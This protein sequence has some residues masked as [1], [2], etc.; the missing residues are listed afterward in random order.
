[1]AVEPL[2]GSSMSLTGSAMSLN[3][4][5]F[6]IDIIDCASTY[7]IA[8]ATTSPVKLYAYDQNCKASLVQ[9]TYA[10]SVY[11][12]SVLGDF[13]SGS[14]V[15]DNSTT[16]ASPSLSVSVA[17]QLPSPLTDASY[18]RFY[19]REIEK[20]A[21]YAISN[22]SHSEG[23]EVMGLEA[24]NLTLGANAVVLASINATGNPTFDIT[25]TCAGAVV[26]TTCETPL[27]VAQD[28]LDMEVFLVPEDGIINATADTLT[29][30]EADSIFTTAVTVAP[31]LADTSGTG[32]A[33]SIEQGTTELYNGK[34]MFL[35]VKYNDATI[36]GSYRYW[37]V[38]IGDPI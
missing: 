29:I 2:P 31:L 18:A 33:I 35:I 16:P 24:P 32:F 3:A 4:T 12:N 5:A 30:G 37:N 22:Y 14:A 1:M 19:F 27:G 28:M 23:L 17:Q 11:V 36:G 9:F 8:G 21:D 20:G 34:N 26:G 38:D 7:A 10:G 13:T 6:Q 25:F 15:F